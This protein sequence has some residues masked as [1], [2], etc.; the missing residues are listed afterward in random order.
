MRRL[1]S[2][3][4]VE[5]VMG[6]EGWENVDQTDGA[7]TIR[8]PGFSGL[9]RCSSLRMESYRVLLSPPPFLSFSGP[10]SIE[11]PHPPQR[12]ANHYPNRQN[13]PMPKRDL[14]QRPR[15]LLPSPDPKCGRTDDDLLQGTCSERICSSSQASLPTRS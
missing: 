5:D 12:H 8:L 3:K 11:I 14:R 2:R 7:F 15:L 9:L 13:S 4:E 10:A 6:D 1:R